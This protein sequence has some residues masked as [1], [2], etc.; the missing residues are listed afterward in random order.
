MGHTIYGLC[1]GLMH[2]GE[3]SDFITWRA[4][5]ARWT[6]VIQWVFAVHL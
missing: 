2:E 4:I 3:Y 6:V 1:R 5:E